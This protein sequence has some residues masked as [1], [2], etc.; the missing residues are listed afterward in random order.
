MFRRYDW[1]IAAIVAAALGWAGWHLWSVRSH[2][3]DEPQSAWLVIPLFWAMVA[4]AP[5]VLLTGRESARATLEPEDEGL[6]NPRRLTFA[7]GILATA[8]AIWGLGLLAASAVV[9]P[10]LAFALGERSPLNLLLAAVIPTG[11]LVG[12]FIM[13]LGVRLPLGPLWLS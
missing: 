11:L 8:A 10:A 3:W 1:S 9:P 12:G 6:A 7:V 4:A 5:F 13:V 2:P